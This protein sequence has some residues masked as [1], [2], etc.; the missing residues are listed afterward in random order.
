MVTHTDSETTLHPAHESRRFD[1]STPPHDVEPFFFRFS[2]TGGG[3]PLKPVEP[4]RDEGC[5]PSRNQPA[6]GSQSSTT[7]T[8]VSTRPASGRRSVPGTA[9]FPGFLTPPVERV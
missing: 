5:G 1:G 2:R 3:R 4:G 7:A 9:N 8:L 6:P